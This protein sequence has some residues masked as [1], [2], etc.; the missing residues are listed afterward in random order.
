MSAQ[1]EVF[2]LPVLYCKKERR[3]RVY[4]TADDGRKTVWRQK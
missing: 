4:K 2:G 1:L 3:A